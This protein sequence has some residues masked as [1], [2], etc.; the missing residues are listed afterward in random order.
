M[1]DPVLVCGLE[2]VDDLTRDHDGFR[3][4][5]GTARDAIGERFPLDQ[6]EH[7]RAEA[8]GFFDTVNR[9]DVWMFECGK[10][11]CFA[12]ESREPLGVGRQ[13]FPV[14]TSA[15]RRA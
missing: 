9:R 8:R 3:N 10:R 13:R 11:L 14:E 12:L 1:H 6:L 2:R 5:Y 4:G 15:R 7:E